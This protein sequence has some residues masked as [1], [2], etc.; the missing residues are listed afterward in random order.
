MSIPALAL[1]PVLVEDRTGARAGTRT[2]DAELLDRATRNDYG[3]WLATALA[4][5]GCV[6]PIRLRGIVRDIDPATG[7]IIRDLDTEDLPDKAIYVPCGDRRASVCPPCAETYRADTYQLIRAGLAGGKGVPE[8]V[9]FHPC[10][11]AT[12]TAPSYGPVHTRVTTA[13]GQVAR[14]RPRRKANY[15]P[16]GQRLSCGRRHKD[17]DPFL[18]R[19]LCPDCYDYD[20]SVVWNAHAPELWRRT[21]IGIRRQLDKLAKT[22]GTRVRLSYAKVAEFQRRG[23]IHFHAIFRLDGIDP[24]HPE[25]TAPPHPAFTAD[26][27]ADV[28]RQVTTATA[29]ITAS[30]PAKPQGWDIRW[31]AQIDPRVVQA[32]DGQ[33]TDI[34]VASYLAKYATKSTEPVGALLERVTTENASIYANPATHQGRLISACLKL[35]GHPHDDFRA[36]RRWA[37]MLGYRGHFATKSRRYSTTMRALRTAR[38]GWKRRQHPQAHHDGD[39]PIITLTNL[40]WA[41]RG[42]RTTGDAVLAL[43]AAARTREH[44]RIARE[45]A[46]AA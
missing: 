19:P 29:F 26:V 22:H 31:G 23:L 12:F 21:V 41:G 13:N 8:S 35:G 4:A 46:R 7:E 24:T 27:L 18:G 10:V 30:H 5:G 37:H 32:A 2:I 44:W 40:A 14:C 16:H 42:W 38:R 17:G 3:R 43:S 11:F 33:I 6:R 9:A 20:A 1:A 36:L 45:E 39:Q 28:I 15:C 34:A 25:R